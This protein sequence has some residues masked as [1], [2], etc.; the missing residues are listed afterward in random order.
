MVLIYG[1][2]VD[3]AEAARHIEKLTRLVPAEVARIMNDQL[4]RVVNTAQGSKGLGLALA[5]LVALY[6]ASR[7]A[8]A[9]VTALNI[10]FDAKET[11]SFPRRAILNAAIVAGAIVLAALLAFAV[12]LTRF[13]GDIAGGLSP[14]ALLAVKTVSWLLAAGIASLGVALL[15]RYA[16][17]RDGAKWRWLTPGAIATVAGLVAASLGFGWFVT[18]IASYGATYG[19]LASIVVLLMWLFISAY[20]LMLGAELNAELEHQTGQDTTRGRERPL[21]ARGA[22]MADTAPAY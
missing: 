4:Q 18:N 11:R 21:G 1:L 6:G 22:Q 20:V 15:F 17:A 13:L 5:L 16:P 3:P 19:A 2:V 8:G 12:S 9:I 10:A 7:G 14:L